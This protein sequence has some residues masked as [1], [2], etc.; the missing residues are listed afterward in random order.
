M[1]KGT[2]PAKPKSWNNITSRIVSTTFAGQKQLN[3][4][5]G[6]C[7]ITIFVVFV[8]LQFPFLEL[9]AWPKPFVRQLFYK[10][11][12]SKFMQKSKKATIN[13]TK[14]SLVKLKSWVTS[15]SRMTSSLLNTSNRIVSYVI[16]YAFGFLLLPFYFPL[17]SFYMVYLFRVPW[18]NLNYR[19][20]ARYKIMKY[21][22]IGYYWSRR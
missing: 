12:L 13:Y 11:P 4:W 2:S 18:A 14:N 17:M 6:A 20:R 5:A 22:I 8:F 10:S 7:C 3:N 9:P 1:H 19:K 16:S 21:Q 15:P